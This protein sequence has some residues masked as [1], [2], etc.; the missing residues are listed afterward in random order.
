[1]SEYIYV[2]EFVL[3]L[4]PESQ[5]STCIIITQDLWRRRKIFLKIIC[6]LSV[7]FIAFWILHVWIKPDLPRMRERWKHTWGI[8]A[9][10][11][12]RLLLLYFC[13]AKLFTVLPS[14]V[15]HRE[16]EVCGC[17]GA[18]LRVWWVCVFNG[19]SSLQRF[20]AFLIAHLFVGGLCFPAT[21][22]RKSKTRGKH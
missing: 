17:V 9:V 13:P 11:R 21:Q 12:K 20:V 8:S 16:N 10:Q 19:P 18:C 6:K 14:C 5:C 15:T 2:N 22:L 7:R 1:M 4:L 3:E